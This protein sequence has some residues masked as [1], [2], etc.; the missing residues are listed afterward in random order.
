MFVYKVLSII[1]II[2]LININLAHASSVIGKVIVKSRT[3]G[4][5]DLYPLLSSHKTNF[6]NDALIKFIGGIL[7]VEKGTSLEAK[8]DNNNINF[9]ISN[10]NINFRIDPSKAVVGF[11]TPNGM[12]MTE[13]ITKSSLNNVEGRIEINDNGTSLVK[14]QYGSLISVSEDGSTTKIRN[15]QAIILS[16]SKIVAQGDIETKEPGEVETES[17]DT[18]VQTEETL[19]AVESPTQLPAG[20]VELL[21]LVGAEAFAKDEILTT[22][23]IAFKEDEQF[24]GKAELVDYAIQPTDKTPVGTNDPV[25]VVCIGFDENQKK[26]YLV[27]PYDNL[28]PE[29]PQEKNLVE[30][31]V[32]VQGLLNPEGY[33]KFEIEE[34]GR[35]TSN[36]NTVAVDPKT[37]QPDESANVADGAKLE[38]ICVRTT[39]IVQPKDIVNENYIN[40]IGN[41]A[42]AKTFN[43]PTG[44]VI[45]NGVDYPDA[46]VVDLNLQPIKNVEFASGTQFTVVGAKPD[47]ND[48]SK[49]ILLVQQQGIVPEELQFAVGENAIATADFSK[50]GVLDIKGQEWW[51]VVVDKQLAP[52]GDTTYSAG[53][54]FAVVAV[55]TSLLAAPAALLAALWSTGVPIII[56]PLAFAGVAGTAIPLAI[57]IDNNPFASPTE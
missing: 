46:V 48:P 20:L 9:Y 54:Q 28:Y 51:G 3:E 21:N 4:R 26:E 41:E 12:V 2:S 18:G 25:K 56:A 53:T 23:E 40:L 13:H 7:V 30:R 31:T 16:E 1:L 27:R 57:A 37:M 44:L 47:E 52:T 49:T 34:Q 45:V 33:S 8:E 32:I 11:Y 39:L 35:S 38:V 42:V 36:W 22:G 29:L 43:S 55:T 14:L 17:T 6:G 50:Y 10:G 19:V 15:G 5:S 24:D